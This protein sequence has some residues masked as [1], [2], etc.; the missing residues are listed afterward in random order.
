M[1]DL[2][3]HP[4]KDIMDVD[5]IESIQSGLATL[6]DSSYAGFERIQPPSSTPTRPQVFICVKVCTI[7]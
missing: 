6:P 2:L 5:D 1:D 3:N 7:S 4:N